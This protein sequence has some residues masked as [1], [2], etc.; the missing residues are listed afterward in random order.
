MP[1]EESSSVAAT[2]LQPQPSVASVSLSDEGNALLLT[3]AVKG[4]VLYSPE[5]KILLD[6][7]GARWRWGTRENDTPLVVAYRQ[8]VHGMDPTD[9]AAAKWQN[10]SLDWGH[11]SKAI[12][13]TKNDPV[14]QVKVADLD[15]ARWELN[16]PG[17]V[18]DLHTLERRP[19]TPDALHTKITTFQPDLDTVPERFL[20]FLAQTFQNAEEPARMIEFVQRLAGHSV[21]GEVR[22]HILPFLYGPGANGKTVLMEIFLGVLG[23]YAGA[24]PSDLLLVGGKDVNAIKADLAGKRLVVCSEVSPT[25]RFH[26]ERVK[27][28]TG[29][30]PV[31]GRRLYENFVQFPPSHSIWMMGNHEP[32]MA[33]GGEA[34][35]RRL[36]KVNFGYTVPEADRVPNLAAQ[37]VAEEGPAIL[38]WMLRGIAPQMD[39]LREPVEVMAATAS[40]A[41]EEDHIARFMEERLIVAGGHTRKQPKQVIVQ[42]YLRWC[43][44]NG[45]KPIKTAMLGRELKRR[46]LGEAKS[47][48]RELY[49]NVDLKLPDHK[50]TDDS[51]PEQ[52]SFE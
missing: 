46:G 7:D 24:A 5:R 32:A 45:E 42:E 47:N 8:L 27:S 35:F 44:R 37:I 22:W 21:L 1:S 52:Q 39:S 10:R 43:E 30:E 50:I 2:A 11:C 40:Y 51:V 4:H 38:G 26:E 48:G 14:L 23:D 9:E 34:I 31:E 49:T 16:T 15:S 33:M 28:L 12:A 13:Y 29:G 25:A 19:P 41:E 18:V 17:G 20:Y 3:G 36:R 6:W